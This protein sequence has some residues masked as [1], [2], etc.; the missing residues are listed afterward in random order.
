MSN[1]LPVGDEKYVY[2][3]F[4]IFTF[5][6][7]WSISGTGTALRALSKIGTFI[8][9]MGA[10]VKKDKI[11]SEDVGQ[12]MDVQQSKKMQTGMF[13]TEQSGKVE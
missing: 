2:H 8:S 5:I 6:F 1:T 7:E 12:L 9:K 11:S 4:L 10:E 13:R 3:L